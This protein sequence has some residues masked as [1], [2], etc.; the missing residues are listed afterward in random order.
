MRTWLAKFSQSGPIRFVAFAAV[1]ATVP[2]AALGQGQPAGLRLVEILRSAQ[3][4][5]YQGYAMNVQGRVA[6]G[7]VNTVYVSNGG[8]T[9]SCSSSASRVQVPISLPGSSVTDHFVLDYSDAGDVLLRA[10]ASSGGVGRSV[11]LVHRASDGQTIEVANAPSVTFLGSIDAAGRVVYK[12]GSSG[13]VTLYD[14]TNTALYVLPTLTGL[15]CPSNPAEFCSFNPTSGGVPRISN[16][17]LVVING[18][19]DVTSTP[20]IE[21]LAGV[22]RTSAVGIPTEIVVGGDGSYGT[23]DTIRAADINDAGTVAFWHGG[24]VSVL[25]AGSSVP[26]PVAGQSVDGITISS[27]STPISI[28]GGSEV[29]FRGNDAVGFGFFIAGIDRPSEVVARGCDLISTTCPGSGSGFVDP[30]MNE[31]GQVAMATAP[32][33]RRIFRADPPGATKCNPK[34]YEVVYQ[35]RRLLTP[36]E[37]RRR[38]PICFADLSDPYHV[39]RS[40]CDMLARKRFFFG[41]RETIP[42]VCKAGIASACTSGGCP[43]PSGHICDAGACPDSCCPYVPVFSAALSSEEGLP[44]DRV[45]G[46]EIRAQSGLPPLGTIELPA[47]VGDGRYSLHLADGTGGWTDTGIEVVGG[48]AFD[49]ESVVPGGLSELAIG[50]IEPEAEVDPDTGDG[51]VPG[52]SV[53]GQDD[54]EGE[55]ELVPWVTPPHCSDGLDNDGDGQVDAADVGCSEAADLYEV[56]EALPCDDG[57]DNDGDGRADS[58]PTPDGDPGCRNALSTTERPQCQDGL[59]NDNQLGI[60]FDGGASLD[61]DHNGFIDAAFNPATPAIGAADAQCM[62]QGW[63]VAEKIGCGLGFELVLL[64]PLL[65]PLARRR[66]G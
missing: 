14:P 36:V 23:T 37:F 1:A 20:T 38:F 48:L 28:G 33:G 58:R 52:F 5:Q 18:T 8:T 44:P 10:R 60:D 26:V 63:R 61:L 2:I 50:G 47:E 46:Y 31:V 24:E 39:I 66:S 40:L 13:I 3:N 17:G 59:N 25:A 11:L 43:C 9:D 35:E 49:L 19:V 27:T 15:P 4:L 29:A 12:A 56:S 64:V 34:S 51:F 16:A 21:R 42:F 57:V 41:R 54:A 6:Y 22:A 45:I 55:I 62:G 7:G 65:G 32:I 30:R 53:V